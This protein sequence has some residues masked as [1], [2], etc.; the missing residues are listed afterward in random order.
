MECF[1]WFLCCNQRRRRN[2]DGYPHTDLR[3]GVSCIGQTSLVIT[4][5]SRSSETSIGLL[6]TLSHE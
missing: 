6:K 5:A 4:V 1:D 3:L 2:P